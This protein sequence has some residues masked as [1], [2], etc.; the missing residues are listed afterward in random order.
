MVFG[1]FSQITTYFIARIHF[2]LGIN[3]LLLVSLEERTE[4]EGVGFGHILL[5]LSLLRMF[6]K[7]QTTS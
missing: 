1:I 4:I 2:Q 3:I 5:K 7:R 6:L